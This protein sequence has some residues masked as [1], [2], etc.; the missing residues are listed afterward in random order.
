MA[1]DK[2]ARA[3][4]ILGTKRPVLPSPAEVAASRHTAAQ[5]ARWGI[6]WPPAAGWR[7]RLEQRWKAAQGDHVPGSSGV[8]SE[9]EWLADSGRAKPTKAGCSTCHKDTNQI[10]ITDGLCAN[11][12]L[13]VLTFCSVPCAASGGYPWVRRAA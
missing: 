3:N 6:R 10:L 8:P 12:S 4:A 5:L 13:R 1:G 11:G 2:I 7:Q 9:R